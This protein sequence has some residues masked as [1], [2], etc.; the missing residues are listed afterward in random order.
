[1]TSIR[2]QKVSRL[3][4]KEISDIFH[5]HGQNWFPNTMVSVTVVRVAPDLGFAKIYLSVFGNMEPKECVDMANHN[6]KMIRGELGRRVKNQLR[7]VPEIV[8]H[9][10][11]S[12]DYAENIEELLSN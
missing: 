2:Q 12:I 3:I 7:V 11:D 9:V 5:H 6:V 8:F 10:D 4:Q 1:M